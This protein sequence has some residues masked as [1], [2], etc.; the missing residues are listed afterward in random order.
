MY[1]SKFLI[2]FTLRVCEVVFDYK[3]NLKFTVN[4][5]D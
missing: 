4:K 5:I 3:A 1:N 2:G